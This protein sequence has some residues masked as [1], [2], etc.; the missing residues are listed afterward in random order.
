MIRLSRG[1]LL[2]L[3]TLFCIMQDETVRRGATIRA[4]AICSR[5]P[6]LNVFRVRTSLPLPFIVRGRLAGSTNNLLVRMYARNVGQPLLF[7]A[8]QEYFHEED[9]GVLRGLF[10]S[11]NNTDLSRQKVCSTPSHPFSLTHTQ[12]IVA[13]NEANRHNDGRVA[14]DHH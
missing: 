1:S 4:I 7:R 2:P 13:A 5:L 6:F 3:L 8:L 11:I 10:T 9:V 14:T 12:V